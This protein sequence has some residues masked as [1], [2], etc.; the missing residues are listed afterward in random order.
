MMKLSVLSFLLCVVAK[1]PREIY[2]G[3][4]WRGIN[5]T[6]TTIRDGWLLEPHR[7]VT[8]DGYILTIFR[9]HRGQNCIRLRQPPVLIMHGLLLSSDS[10]LDSDAGLGYLISDQCYDV[11][12][13]NVRGNYYSRNHLT[14]NP[15]IDPEFWQFYL[16]D[17]GVSDLPAIIDYILYSTR[18]ERL[19]YIGYSQSGGSL[20]IMCSERQEYCGKVRSAML[21]NPATRMKYTS[22][23]AFRLLTKFYETFRPHLSSARNLEVFPIGGVIQTTIASLCDKEKDAD[24]ICRAILNLIDS[25]HSGSIVAETMKKLS[26]HFPAGTSAKSLTWFSQTLNADDFKKFNYGASENLKLYGDVD[27]PLY[28]MNATT[29][30]VVIIYGKNDRIVSYKDIKWLKLQLPNILEVFQI[31]DP[32]WNHF[33]TPYSQHNNKMI[34]PK[35]NE[36]LLKY[37]Y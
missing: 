28:N 7:V 11:W 20:V 32:L 36:Y 6:E 3:I 26:R 14:L 21:L 17:V 10:W 33:D 2:G 8:N 16:N 18:S 35:I 24:V 4:R 1:I 23:P 22:S 5:F 13:G 29:V 9:L 30:P 19:N 37:S 27:P 31:G 25:R 12:L 34:M 15:D